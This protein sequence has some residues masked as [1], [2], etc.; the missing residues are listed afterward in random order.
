M[1]AL[2]CH[3]VRGSCDAARTAR[4]LTTRARCAAGVYGDK[5]TSLERF[6]AGFRRLS[7][8]CQKRLT[9][10]VCAPRDNCARGQDIPAAPAS[11]SS[12]PVRRQ[13]YRDL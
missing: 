1:N 13:C 8:A 4:T 3:A 12:C 9:V 10:E 7:P 2:F 6:A 5:V 11:S